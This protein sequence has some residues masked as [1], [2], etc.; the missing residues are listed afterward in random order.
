V[1]RVD[2]YI[3][4][5]LD[6]A[7][8]FTCRLTE[9]AYDQGHRIF[10]RA[11]D[12]AQAQALDRLLWSFRQGSF[13]PHARSAAA[14]DEPIV[15]GVAGEAEPD[16]GD[17]LINLAADLPPQW[18]GFARLAEVVAGEPAL[19]AARRRF[20]HYREAGTDPHYHKLDGS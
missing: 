2:F 16:R 10:I 17:L 12:A 13:L 7:E 6:G 4:A 15:L 3:L 8:P 1:Q 19:A 5:D 20:R 9:K 11:R 14:T 18:H